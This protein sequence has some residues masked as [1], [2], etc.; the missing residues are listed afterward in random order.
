[1]TLNLKRLPFEREY[2]RAENRCWWVDQD[3]DTINKWNR[4]DCP[5]CNSSMS[6]YRAFIRGPG[7]TQ[8]V[9]VCQMCY[10]KFG[11]GERFKRMRK[12]E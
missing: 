6:V 3:V 9:L 4:P 1:M 10:R 5:W 12:L 8:N 2:T 7:Y 11:S